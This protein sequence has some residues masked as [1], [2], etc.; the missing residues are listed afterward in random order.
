MLVPSVQ[1]SEKSLLVVLGTG[2]GKEEPTPYAPAVRSAFVDIFLS[3]AH[4]SRQAH[5]LS[6]RLQWYLRFAVARHS[7][8]DFSTPNSHRNRA[9]DV[10]DTPP[11]HEHN[12]Q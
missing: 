10:R 8:S 11:N 2:R 9:S 6:C 12:T 3:R 4:N 1:Y 5:N 7:E